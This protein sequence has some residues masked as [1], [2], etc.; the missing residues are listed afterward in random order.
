MDR[1]RLVRVV[2][3]AP[4]SGALL[5]VGSVAGL[6]AD[7]RALLDAAAQDDFQFSAAWFA[8]VAQAALPPG[9]RPLFLLWRETGRTVALLALQRLASGRLAGL[10]SPY[11]CRFRPLVAATATEAE[12]RRAGDRFG[13]W[14]RAS[15]PLRLEALDPDWPG[16]APLL[17]GLRAAGVVAL[18]FAQFGNWYL[19]LAGLDWAGYLAGRP[20][21]LRATIRRRVAR[22]ARDPAIAFALI[23][24]GAALEAGIAAY[25]SV[26]AS[27]WKPPEPYPAFGPALLRAAAGAG[28]LRLGVLRQGGAPVAA[29]YWTLAGGTATVLKLAH[30]ERA[31]ALSPGTVLTALM[32]RHLLER[33]GA[34]VLDFGRGDDPYKAGWTGLRR[35]RE[36]LLLCPLAHPAGLAAL[37]RHGLG[38]A[39]RRLPGPGGGDRSHGQI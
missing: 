3:G 30:D 12:L 4:V 1:L 27:S 20:G 26:H 24:G 13:R 7:A 10:T 17:A 29:Q 5:A 32:I 19:P 31:R 6:P 35:P 2:E 16:R 11:T 8:A 25:E 36:G 22:A 15:G 33:D 28:V 37:A 38:R 9:A 18:R 21:A 39:L 23:S 14:W 34:A